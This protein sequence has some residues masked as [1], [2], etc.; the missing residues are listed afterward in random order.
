[1]RIG[2]DA[3]CWAN[4]RG[5]GRYTRELLT[6]LLSVDKQNEYLFFIDAESAKQADDLPQGVP[7]VK[8]TTS[9]AATQ[10]ASASGRRSL[11]DLWA[12]RQAVYRHGY[13]LDLFYFPSVYTYFPPKTRARV[14]VTIHDTTAER[15]PK[16]I[17]PNR[18]SRLFWK[19]KVQLAV[20]RA[21]LIA[22][23]SEASKREITKEFGV[24]EDRVSV[25]SDAV[26]AEFYPL[27]QE[28]KT[29]EVVARYGVDVEEPF[30]LYVGGISPHKNLHTLVDAHALLGQ[31]SCASSANLVLVGDYQKD[32]F[33]SSYTS[34][35]EKIDSLG[36]TDKVVFTGFVDDADLVY[37]YNAASVLVMPSYDEGFGLPALEA[38]ACGTPVIASN[39]GALPEV[40]GNAGR[41][42]SPHSPQ[43]LKDHLA[44][45]L[46][47][48]LVHDAMQRMG[49]QRA[50]EFSWERSAQAALSAFSQLGRSLEP[51]TA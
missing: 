10:A 9:R 4:Q 48:R 17:F 26:G 40:V 44:T 25:I 24:A 5:Y 39:T 18:R 42:F 33:Y 2:V 41:L 35:R 30:I 16:L 19:L 7:Q 43:H 11:R 15:Y 50:R 13:D 38:M 6:A 49:L 27:N 22:T 37:L 3:S 14:I 8:V 28:S 45:V 1:M 46:S 31:E 12:M 20:R 23:V 29:R 32:V 47:D 34:L 36:T 51:A 21:D